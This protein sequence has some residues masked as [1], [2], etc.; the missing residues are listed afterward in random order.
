MNRV[1]VSAAVV[2]AAATTVHHHTRSTPAT[3]KPQFELAAELTSEAAPSPPI[4]ITVK[5]VVL[6]TAAAVPVP[7][8]TIRWWIKATRVAVTAMHSTARTSSAQ[9]AP[10]PRDYPSRL[11][12]LEHSLMAR[13]MER[14]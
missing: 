2:T 7:P 9:G 10:A 5:E 4:L 14:L 1:H 8:T 13:E 12:Y 6:S 3:S 11:G